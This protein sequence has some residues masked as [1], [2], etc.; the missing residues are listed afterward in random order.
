M[1]EAIAGS[2]G[3][4]MLDVRSLRV[5]F[6]TGGGLGRSA[7]DVLAVDGV[8][9]WVGHGETLGL[10]G[11]SGS[12]KSTLGR[13]ILNLLPA[14]AR[15]GG[16]VLFQGVPLV[17][18][19]GRALRRQRRRLQM[20]FQDPYGSL[21]PRMRVSQLLGDPL[22]IHGLARGKARHDRVAELLELVGLDRSV[23]SRFPHTF[24]GGQR[25][26]IAIARALAPEPDL[27]VCDEPVTA[28]DVSVQA[29][30]LNLLVRL[31][32]ELGLSYLFIA[33]DLATVRHMSDRIA[34]M[35]LGKIVEI[36]A[37]DAVYYEPSHPYSHALVSA[38]PAADPQAERTR[39]RIVL[40]SGDIPSP[41]SIPPGCRFHT[42]CWLYQRLGAPEDCRTVEPNLRTLSPVTQVA[43]HHAEVSA[44]HRD[45]LAADLDPEVL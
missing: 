14:E 31:Q 17:S 38:I 19:R 34:V 28:L 24:S 23:S 1:N 9:L 21:N 29:Q 44:D 12:G 25:Q 18:M 33:H 22:T 16:T 4:H 11:E 39:E 40:T 30:I 7:A 43:C 32:A 41:S 27:M 3:D 42:R 45:D 8:N 5:R 20:V 37:A 13:A 10:V 26:R 15:V 36:G 2:G 35:Y 6:R